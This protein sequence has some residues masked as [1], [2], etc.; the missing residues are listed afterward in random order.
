MLE[1][2]DS[3]LPQDVILA[4]LGMTFE[5]LHRTQEAIQSYQRI[6]DEFPQS[7]YRQEAQQKVSAL[8]P[9]RAPAGAALPAGIPG[10]PG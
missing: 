6:V 9:T 10:F 7:P 1:K 5:Q 8:D 2:S 4:E 3:P